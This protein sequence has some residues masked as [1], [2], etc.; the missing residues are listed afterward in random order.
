MKYDICLPNSMEGFL[1]PTSFAGPADISY[2]AQV[3]EQLNYNA[4]WGFDFI[5]PTADMGIANDVVANWYEL[6][7]TLAYLAAVTKRIRLVAGVVV[8]PNRD[9]IILAKQVATVDQFSGGRLD[10]GIGLG[11]KPEFDTMNPR[12]RGVYR[13]DLVDE[14]L[15]ALQLLL[16]GGSKPVSFEGKYVSFRNVNLNPKP[17]QNPLPILTAA[18]SS[19]PLRRAAK[20]KLNPIIHA[21]A[22]DERLEQ[23]RPELKKAG[24]TLAEFEKIAWA[25]LRVDDNRETAVN[26]YLDSVMAK[27]AKNKFRKED[28]DTIV[29]RNWV[30]TVDE[31]VDR[32]VLLK[33]R[34]I[35]RVVIMHTV[36]E[37]FDEMVSQARKFAEE[38]VPKVESA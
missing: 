20:W 34:G 19:A 6:M 27:F 28:D 14:R 10:L 15:E 11:L 25:D 9:P 4:V 30:G 36:T 33:R 8:L 22:L 7:T 24:R 5:N 31:I 2:F 26:R 29:T 35:D 37:T 16:R 17:V 18:E 38:I 13:G 32:L 21:S 23:F 1:A 3:A 12:L